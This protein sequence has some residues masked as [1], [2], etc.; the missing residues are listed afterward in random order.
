MKHWNISQAFSIRSRMRRP[1]RDARYS[2]HCAAPAVLVYCDGTLIHLLGT[3]T[4]LRMPLGISIIGVAWLDSLPLTPRQLLRLNRYLGANIMPTESFA[5][6]FDQN[7][8]QWTRQ[9]PM[10]LS[11]FTARPLVMAELAPVSGKHVLDLGCGEGY[12]ARL[13][14]QA[15]AQSVFGIDISSEMVGRAQQAVASGAP[16]PMTFVSGNA[17]TFQDFP[18]PQFDRVIAVFMVSYLS[19]T[20]MTEVF[21]TVRSRL[22]PGGRFVFTVPHP[23]L[24]YIRQQEKPVYFDS[25]GRDYFAGVDESYEG[26]IWRRDGKAV[27]VSYMHK[28]FA[29]YFNALA[30]AGFQVLPKVI[31]LKVT[32]EHLALDRAFFEGAVGYPLQVL[33]RID[34]Q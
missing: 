10:I 24:P 8:D 30:A 4:A 21:R 23:F 28:T 17:T 12:V 9:E 2:S 27:P 33:F 1:A 26:Y 16:C 31:E 7:A 29:D 3:H 11:D 14:A 32:Q 6:M 15:G 22:A 18:R 19:C 25:K 34:A 20:E 5:G 13:V